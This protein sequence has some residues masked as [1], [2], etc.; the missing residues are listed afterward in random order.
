MYSQ[1]R[2]CTSFTNLATGVPFTG[3]THNAE[4]ERRGTFT[5]CTLAS[6]VYSLR[7]A[8]PVGAVYL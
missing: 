7:D 5:Q 6:F 8:F 3:T 2:N 1:P 4:S